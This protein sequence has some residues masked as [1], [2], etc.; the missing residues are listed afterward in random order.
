MWLSSGR[1]ECY[2]GSEEGR[3]YRNAE[4]VESAAQWKEGM[5]MWPLRS[6]A[7]VEKCSSSGKEWKE[8]WAEGEGDVAAEEFESAA[9]VKEGNATEGDVAAEE[10]E[11]AAQV[12]GGNATEG[13]VAAEGGC[14]NGESCS[15]VEEECYSS[16][17]RRE[18]L[19]RCGALEELKWKEGM[20]TEGD[21]AA[22]EV[23]SAAQ[24]EGGN[25]TEGDDVAL[26]RL[27]KEIVAAEEVES[28]AQFGR[29]ECPTEG[30]VAA[31]E[32][33]SAAQVEG[34]NAAEEGGL[35]PAYR[36]E[37]AEEESAA[38]GRRTEGM[39]PN[40]RRCGPLRSESA[41]QVGRRECYR[42]RCGR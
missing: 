7:Q 25:A 35:W 11:S 37:C 12:E 29:R 33:E 28:A 3:S 14:L 18:M 39:W 27:K 42:R 13:D 6:A 16:S 40:R 17:G 38:Q 21:V 22:E 30:D 19:R 9:Q 8:M 4:E 24:V 10:V 41:A 32:V 15:S 26:R 1:R 20:L 34:G 36:G 2:R 31:E 5:L 23:E